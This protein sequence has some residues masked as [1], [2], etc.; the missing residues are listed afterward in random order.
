MSLAVIVLGQRHLHLAARAIGLIFSTASVGALVGSVSASRIVARVGTGRVIIGGVLLW[1]VGA[2]LVASSTS[3]P[4][5]LGGELLINVLAPL[6]NVAVLTYRMTLIPD[7]LQGRVNSAYRLLAFGGIPLGMTGGGLLLAHLDPRVVL[8]A[9][10]IGLAVTALA[11][12][13]TDV[14]RAA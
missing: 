9:I 11:V 13:A 5:L 12:G 4:L 1:A 10:A 8:W 3:A 6:V 2:A 14:R 7:V